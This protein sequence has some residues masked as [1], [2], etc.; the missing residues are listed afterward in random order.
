MTGTVLW[1]V[2]NIYA[3]DSGENVVEC[4]IKG[5]VLEGRRDM[6]NPLAPGD[7][8][9]FGTDPHDPGKGSI[10]AKSERKNGFARWNKKRQAPQIIA[11][12]I[13]ACYCITSPES[14][15]FRPRF[16]DRVAVVSEMSEIPLRVVC[17]KSDQTFLERVRGRLENYESI[18]YPVF[19]T[20]ATE[21]YGIGE[22]RFSMKEQRILFIGQ[23][24]V[25]KS[26][27][28]NSLLPEQK[29]KTSGIS[30]KYNR[31][32]HTTVFS[33]LLKG[34]DFDIIDTPGIREIEIFGLSKQDLIF[35]FPDLEP[36]QSN[37]RFPSCLHID[38]PE[39][40]VKAALS[41]GAVHPDR[42][43]SYVRIFQELKIRESNYG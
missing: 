38:E 14:P 1:G 42:Y 11:A 29:R 41:E 43:E 13:D 15:P 3:V 8:V 4:R 6:Y 9:V 39:C 23:S 17:N 16:I 18:G 26:T 20:S 36:F 7:E 22:L 37:C 30:E 5:K 25:G 21:G 32:K 10:T 24:G 28:I 34:P 35:C 12:N 27:L 19:Y 40:G 2:N 33:E 31:G